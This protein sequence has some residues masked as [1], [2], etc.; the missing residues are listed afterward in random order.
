MKVSLSVFFLCV[1][2]V[3]AAPALA[4]TSLPAS[5]GDPKIK[6]DVKTQKDKLPLAPP[7]PGKAQ[8]VFLERENQRVTPFSSATVRFGVD[9]TWSGADY[10]NSYFTQDVDPGEHHLCANW[11]GTLQNVKRTTDLTSLTLEPGKVYY[12][13]AHVTVT[14]SAGHADIEFGLAPVDPDEANFWITQSKRSTFKPK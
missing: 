6:F 7:A 13:A 11:Q 3:S 2:L 9:G 1:L 14:G 10:S 8:I 5:C 4:A 12:L